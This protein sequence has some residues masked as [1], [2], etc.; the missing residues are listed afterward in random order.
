MST[1]FL[2]QAACQL[3]NEVLSTEHPCPQGQWKKQVRRNLL[4]WETNEVSNSKNIRGSATEVL[5]LVQTI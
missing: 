1:E 3:A 5:N 2:C 4:G